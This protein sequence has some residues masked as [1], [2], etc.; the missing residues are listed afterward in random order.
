VL[1][2]SAAVTG[3]VLFHGE[4]VLAMNSA[5]LRDYRW[6]KVSLVMQGA[7]N[8]LNPTMTIE[9]QIVDVV[10][11]HTRVS[12][13]VARTRVPD[14]LELVGIDPGRR[15]AYPHELSG[16]MRQRCVMAVALALGPELVVMDEPTT[17]LDVVVQRSIMDKVDELREQLGFSTILISHDL[18]L[19]TER[20]SRLVIMYGGSVVEAGPAKVVAGNPLHPYTRALL[21]ATMPVDGPVERLHEVP[22][23][24]P[25]LVEPQTGCLF[26][27]RCSQAAPSHSREIPLLRQVEPEHFVACHLYPAPDGQVR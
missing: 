8:A 17:A 26:Y 10:R 2:Q 7:M 13:R 6:A 20:A 21:D 14:L 24:T 22:G 16:G 15:S 19:V 23:Q 9:A 27:P 5:R 18:D 1:H 4:D 3:Q 11:A 25:S 12:R